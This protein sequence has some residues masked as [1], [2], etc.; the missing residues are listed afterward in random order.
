MKGNDALLNS[1]NKQ[2][3]T[4]EEAKASRI[5]NRK[6]QIEDITKKINSLQSTADQLAQQNL[7]ERDFETFESFR[8][9]AEA[10]SHQQKEKKKDI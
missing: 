4:F 8:L 10:Q 9:K 5:S 1:F 3:A 6:K 7:K 2:K